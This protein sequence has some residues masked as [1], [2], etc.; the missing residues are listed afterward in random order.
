M[1]KMC[2]NELMM[3]QGGGFFLALALGI[4]HLAHM[5]FSLGRFRR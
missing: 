3:C 1:E 2:R 4:R 5:I